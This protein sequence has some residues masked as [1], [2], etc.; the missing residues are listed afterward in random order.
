[1]IKSVAGLL[2]AQA[3]LVATLVKLLS[4]SLDNCRR[5]PTCARRRRL[6]QSTSSFE[7]VGS[8]YN[9]DVTPASAGVATMRYCQRQLI[10]LSSRAGSVISE[11]V[12]FLLPS[13]RG[14]V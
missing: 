1:M 7:T 14:C 5:A 6:S 12:G 8:H 3:A 10:G 9:S 4:Y 13:T 11:S 2:L